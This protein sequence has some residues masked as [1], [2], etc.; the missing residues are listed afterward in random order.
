MA[1]VEGVPT[2]RSTLAGQGSRSVVGLALGMAALFLA[3][4]A[5]LINTPILFYMGTA[6]IATIFAI[7]L[8]ARLSVRGLRFRR[9]SPDALK[10]GDWLTIVIDVWSE[11]K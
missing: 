7:R 3:L 10:V 11:K 1:H 6:L 2:N 9:L 4:V 8:Q 5:I